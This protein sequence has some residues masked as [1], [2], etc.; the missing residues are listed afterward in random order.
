MLKSST[1]AVLAV[2]GGVESYI[3]V[4]REEEEVVVGI[5]EGFMRELI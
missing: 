1:K 5:A 3:K 2:R 4:F